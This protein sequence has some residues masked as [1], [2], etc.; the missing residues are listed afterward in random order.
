MGEAPFCHV[1][2]HRGRSI[3][4]DVPTNRLLAV[5]PALAAVLPLHGRLDP[6]R[7]AARLQDRFPAAAIAAATAEI[8][9]AR[10]REALFLAER[11]CVA[12]PGWSEADR[13]ALARGRRQLILEVSEDCNLRCT[14]C[15]HGAEAAIARPH[16]RRRMAKTVAL[17]AAREFMAASADIEAPTICFHGGEPLLALATIA[18]VVREVRRAP[19][20]KRIRF[21]IATNGTLLDR[22]LARTLIHRERIRLQ[23]SL[24]GPTAVHDRH[25]RTA[26]GA[27][28]LARIEANLTALLRD[29]PALADRL[30]LVAT[31]APPYDLAAVG[32]YFASFPPF[33]AA[34][35]GRPPRLRINRARLPATGA[36]YR[37]DA[38]WQAQVARLREE[39][40]A[41]RAG[42]GR[43][44]PREVL[45][46][47]LFDEPL[48][49]WHH[50]SG[51]PLQGPVGSGGC[52][53]PGVRRLFV[54][55]DGSL[56]P[57]ERTA[58]AEI[59][60]SGATGPRSDLI[61]A[62][63]ARFTAAV[64][65]R[66]RDCW[67][68]RQCSLCYAHLAPG[69]ADLPVERCGEVRRQ[70]EGTIRLFLDLRDRG[71]QALQWL[72]DTTI[73]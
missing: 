48:I 28:S 39:Y 67:A 45:L 60:G 6:R 40:V 30:L 12:V 34:G 71:S 54:R 42:G 15:L 51:R 17:A 9:A 27:P 69:R 63:R 36:A 49:A 50:R 25:R 1:F 38:D 22:L 70:L 3:V 33:A 65:D 32:E 26:G 41:W 56:A 8:A 72:E 7:L 57:C 18:A 73:D 47:A 58:P 66:C 43:T 37:I 64:A 59:L 13:L 2:S 21:S 61:E 4:Y 31:L 55:A 10:R 53:R 29:E 62:L 11:P 24:D 5:D 68:V 16:R 35:I 52:C 14:Y 19:G 20:G 46:K 23:I 44:S